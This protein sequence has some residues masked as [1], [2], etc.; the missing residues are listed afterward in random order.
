[1]G[2]LALKKPRANRR[3]KPVKL[4]Q[5]RKG[6]GLW[7][8]CKAVLSLS[9]RTLLVGLL[10]GLILAAVLGVYAGYRT[11]AASPY[12]SLRIVHVEGGQRLKSTE[13]LELAG[14]HI[15]QSILDLDL[16]E[17][18]TRIAASPWIRSVVVSRILPN[19]LKVGIVEAPAAFWV[20]RE[21][22]LYYADERGQSIAQVEMDRFAPL[23][24]A[25]VEAGCEACQEVLTGL[26][27]ALERNEFFFGKH[28]V[29][30]L[31]VHGE[32]G[33]ALELEA[34]AVRLVAPLD[35][36]RAGLLNMRPVMA[37]LL[38]RGELERTAQ[39]KARAGRVW[40]RLI[41]ATQG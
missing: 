9:A 11:M 16:S 31:R 36:W 6:P 26:W 38:R 7:S 40:V 18:E 23:P 22:R 17:L 41:P 4:R 12:F 34:P 1:M 25:E 15:G 13:V 3:K 29:A 2:V 35:D 33:L 8:V 19:T 30:A 28:E 24:L 37:D 21:E 27:T 20:L 14:V 5:P 10:S 39:L 32:Q